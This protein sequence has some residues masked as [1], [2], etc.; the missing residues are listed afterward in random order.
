MWLKSSSPSFQPVSWHRGQVP[1]LVLLARPLL[2][3][4]SGSNREWGLC[5]KLRDLNNPSLGGARLLLLWMVS[6]DMIYYRT[7]LLR[8]GS[9]TEWQLPRRRTFGLR[10]GLSNTLT[11]SSP[12]RGRVSLSTRLVRWPRA[13]SPYNRRYIIIVMGVTYWRSGWSRIRV[14]LS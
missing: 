13:M 5:L 4:C 6:P 11:I 8:W 14:V 12:P 7:H 1:G 2:G 3:P 10:T 9:L